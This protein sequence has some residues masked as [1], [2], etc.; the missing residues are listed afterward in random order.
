MNK[1][2][3]PEAF[4]SYIN[5]ENVED[6]EFIE[7]N[8]FTFT[9]SQKEALEDLRIFQYIID[10][11]YSGRDYWQNNGLDFTEAYKKINEYI[12][13]N[14]I[15]SK[16]EIYKMYYETLQQIH[17][18]HLGLM[19][20]GHQVNMGKKY[21][22]YFSDVLINKRN[23]RFEVIN[24]KI[25]ELTV[26]D[27]F[28]YEQLKDKLFKTLS[29]QGHEHFL[30]GSRSWSELTQIT[31]N[32]DNGIMSIPVH[33]CRASDIEKDD[34]GIFQKNIEE[35]LNV[36]SSSRFWD[37]KEQSFND[38]YECG[39]SLRNENIV[40][41]DLTCN[42]GGNSNYPLQ[43]IKG[44]NE[45]SY[46]KIDC[47]VLSS[48]PI[49][50]AIGGTK[51]NITN[52][53]EWQFYNAVERDTSQGVFNGTLY[54]LSNDSIGS[55]GE[56]ALDIA[57]C[58]KNCVTVGQNSKGAGIFGDVLSYKLPFSDVVLQVP[59]KLFLN[60]AIEGHGFEP[61]F[62]LDSIDLKGELLYWLRDSKNYRTLR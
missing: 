12:M 16:S 48:P 39:L 21:K 23:D 18:G 37:W 6:I 55:S 3:I 52:K 5:H 8:K 10:N 50:Q 51:E 33:P 46:W 43:F 49:N 62:W 22:A 26:G 42:G 44:L 40:I 11:A 32:T 28:T 45:Y 61:D 2:N 57:K 38:F 7:L 54:I 13:Q 34:I 60:G 24:S 47:A 41:W 19:T 59:Y 27:T 36:V 25:S 56:S 53:R 15:L 14:V 1:S 17:D 29:P 58:V 4:H 31:I 30:L 9:I 20:Y 35:G